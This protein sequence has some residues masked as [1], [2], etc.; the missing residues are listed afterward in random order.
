MA[1]YQECPGTD[2]QPEHYIAIY[3]EDAAEVVHAR[4]W[5]NN[6]QEDLNRLQLNM[7]EAMDIVR[8]VSYTHL[9]L[10]TIYS[11]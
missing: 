2:C 9:T 6:I 10:P 11:V 8:A 4:K 7:K 3:R 5:I 1:T